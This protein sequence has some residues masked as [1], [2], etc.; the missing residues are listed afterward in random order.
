MPVVITRTAPSPSRRRAPRGS[1]RTKSTRAILFG[2]VALLAA[3]CVAPPGNT[4]TEYDAV[5]EANHF[6]GCLSALG[7][8]EEEVDAAIDPVLD[9]EG[10][11]VEVNIIPDELPNSAYGPCLC[12]YEDIVENV[13]FADYKAIDSALQ[14][15]PAPDSTAT[16]V[17]AEQ[18][19]AFDAYRE[20][21]TGCG[22]G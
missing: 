18:V 6:K 14:D 13:A 20:I 16:T 22:A 17:P 10:E 9:E 21:W 2:L 8:P 3:A 5:T 7:V 12:V 19:D 4:P 11:I 15:P 1:V